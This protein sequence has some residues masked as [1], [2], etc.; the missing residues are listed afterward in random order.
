[1]DEK[2]IKNVN[3]MFFGRQRRIDLA[4]KIAYVLVGVLAIILIV[5]LVTRHTDFTDK[6]VNFAYLVNYMTE[7]GYTCEMLNRSGGKC[8][9]RRE[10]V[11]YTFYR[12]DD[13][14]Q[15]VLNTE[16]YSLNVKHLGGVDLIEF[17]TN[18]NAFI[19]YRNKEYICTTKNGIL[20]ELDKCVTDEGEELDFKA[21]IGF[22][23][24]TFY[25]L[26]KIMEAAEYDKDA[27]V[28]DYEWIKK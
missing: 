13:G 22:I 4:E 19:N 9:L 1:M 23:N 7:K 28:N 6:N 18:G 20:S 14:L 12:Y 24:E 5:Y 16:S 21:Y 25:E 10:N 2:K 17:K 15:Y 27:L 8:T 11:D 26:D 3:K